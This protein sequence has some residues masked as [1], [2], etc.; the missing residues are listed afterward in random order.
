G[1]RRAFR[2]LALRY[3]PDRAGPATTRSF[4]DI[5]RAY[6]VLSD[7]TR[8]TDYD[9]EH[10]AP[11]DIRVEVAAGP[12]S[13]IVP[14]LSLMRDFVVTSPPASDIFDEFFRTAGL[15]W[16]TKSERGHALDLE[17][18]LS[19]TEAWTGGIIPLIVP[20]FRPCKACHG[21]GH[22][23]DYFCLRCNG[24]GMIQIE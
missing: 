12:E 9:R 18:I 1:I 13:F 6:E 21:N 20:A 16:Q 17:L 2:D 23:F 5:L 24:S 22:S 3:H 7:P 15:G 19:R 11:R 4:Q 14:P 8:R 10:S